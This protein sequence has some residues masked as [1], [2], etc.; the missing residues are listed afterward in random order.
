MAAFTLTVNGIEHTVDVPADMPLLWVLRDV[1]GLTGTK[2]SCGMAL[3][4][5]CVVHV[6]DVAVRSCTATIEGAAGRH[7]TT[8]EGLS[9][10]GNHPVQQAWDEFNVPQCGYCQTGQIMNAAMWLREHPNPSNEDVDRYQAANLCR[11]GT[12]ERIRSAILRA[13]ELAR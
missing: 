13:A 11:C 9:E 5:S 6:E 1:I 2:Y 3:C 4:G 8:I 10:D 12:Y 7:V